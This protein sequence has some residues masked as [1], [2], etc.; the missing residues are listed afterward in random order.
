MAGAMRLGE[1]THLMESRLDRGDAPAPATPA[2]FEALDDDLDRI[3]FVLD[4]LREGKTNVALPWVGRLGRRAGAA[5]R[6]TS[7]RAARL[8]PEAPPAAEAAS[9]SEVPVVTPAA[10]GRAVP[11]RP[12]RRSP[13]PSRASARCC[14]C[15]PT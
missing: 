1:L 8:P 7:R 4:A 15:A 11:Q 14:A 5:R 12:S 9:S 13:K 6:S 3:A 2:L 10:S